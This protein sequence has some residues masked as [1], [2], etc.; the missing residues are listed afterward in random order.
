[1]GIMIML[2]VGRPWIRCSVADPDF[3][4]LLYMDL[5]PAIQLPCRE[6]SRLNLRLAPNLKINGATSPLPTCLKGVHSKKL[7]LT[8]VLSLGVWWPRPEPDHSCRG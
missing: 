6:G 4:K 1:V 5:S 8:Q 2:R 7:P 3:F